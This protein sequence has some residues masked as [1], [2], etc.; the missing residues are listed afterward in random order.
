MSVLLDQVQGFDLLENFLDDVLNHLCNRT[1]AQ[2]QLSYHVSETYSVKAPPVL[3]EGLRLPEADIYGKDFRALP[4]AEHMVLVAWYRDATQLEWTNSEK[5]AVVRL[6]KRN[7]AWHVQPEF[8]QARHILLHS[9]SGATSTGL[10]RLRSPGYKV[11]TDKEIAKLKYPFTP[12]GEIY[13]LFEVE[14]DPVWVNTGI[15]GFS[16][17]LLLR[18]KTGL[19]IN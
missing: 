2:E 5:V 11:Y 15:R 3:Y 16:F 4:P 8:A 1:T 7:G 9:D 14:Q 6:G 12:G 18:M 13:A 19:S 17:R 10:W